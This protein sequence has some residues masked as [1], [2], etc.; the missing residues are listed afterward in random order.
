MVL[1][2]AAAVAAVAAATMAAMACFRFFVGGSRQFW[3][4]LESSRS[5]EARGPT[6]RGRLRTKHL[7]MVQSAG[8]SKDRRRKGACG[9]SGRLSLASSLAKSTRKSIQNRF[10]EGPGH[11]KSLKNR[12]RRP[13]AAQRPPG[14]PPEASREPFWPHFGPPGA[15]FRAFQASFSKL[16]RAPPHDRKRCSKSLPK[17]S[18]ATAAGQMRK[19][20]KAQ[21]PVWG[22]RPTGDPATEPF[23]L[24]RGRERSEMKIPKAL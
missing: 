15:H 20:P 24:T 8:S 2:A 19:T 12:S 16:A 9:R 6:S 1:A 17:G 7:W 11:P 4:P 5:Q 23:R 10:R 3:P 14:T 13:R 21:W 22:R 18:F